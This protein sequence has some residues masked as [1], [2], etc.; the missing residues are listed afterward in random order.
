MAGHAK[1]AQ[2]KLSDEMQCAARKEE[3]LTRAAHLFA[4][5]GY[6]NTDTTLL[7]ETAGVGKGTVYRHFPSKRQLFLAAVDRVMRM[8]LEQVEGQ[9]AGI[10]D[11]IDQI[12]QAVR[13]FLDFFGEKPEFVELLIQERAL[14]RD[15][16]QPTFIEHR[17]RNIRRWQQVYRELIAE[18]R[19]RNIPVDR[20]T[21]I[22]GHLLYGTIFMNY[23]SGSTKS[24][25]EQTD[26]IIDV[27]FRGILTE[28]E[29][30]RRSQ[31]GNQS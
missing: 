2:K 12:I 25:A 4:E 10:A 26:D 27:V 29:M 15:R 1:T 16:T 7:A 24:V 8:L 6:D 5:R 21:D 17:N 13:S 9:I 18:D 31:R 30:K 11:P 14:F 19:V 28:A 22:L 20:I 3:I 23:F